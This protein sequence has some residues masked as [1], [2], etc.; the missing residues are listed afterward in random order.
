MAANLRIAVEEIDRKIV[1]RLD[2]RLDAATA[3]ILEKKID[4]L[5]LEHR[6]VILLDFHRVDYLSSAGLRLLL[7]A[8]KKLKAKKGSLLLCSLGDEV[9]EIVKIAGFDRILRIFPNEQEAL[10]F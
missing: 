1:L 3:P 9:E 6:N 5:L 4:T 7:S 2:G 8:E 10:K